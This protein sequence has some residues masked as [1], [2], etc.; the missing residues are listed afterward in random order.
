MAAQ[1]GGIFSFMFRMLTLYLGWKFMG[2]F[3]KGPYPEDDP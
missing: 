3:I 1:E 2:K